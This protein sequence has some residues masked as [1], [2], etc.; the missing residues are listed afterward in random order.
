[1]KLT[2]TLQQILKEY[3]S[4]R[5]Y[6]LRRRG[7]EAYLQLSL[8]EMLEHSSVDKEKRYMLLGLID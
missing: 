8:Q 3:P 1:V 5:L 4:A 6:L 7:Q 2:M